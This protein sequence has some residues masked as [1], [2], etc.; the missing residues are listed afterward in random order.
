MSNNYRVTE[1]D[2][3]IRD[4]FTNEVYNITCITDKSHV[5]NTSMDSFTSNKDIVIKKLVEDL[6]E[7]NNKMHCFREIIKQF[8]N[9]L[10]QEIQDMI[11]ASFNETLGLETSQK[12]AE[13][14]EPM[15][16]QS[17]FQMP[18]SDSQR[19]NEELAKMTAP[20]AAEFGQPMAAQPN[21]SDDYQHKSR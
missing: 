6:I 17:T 19:I 1:S 5:A 15:A 2:G 14:S 7:T 10:P 11:L 20:K 16:A 21:Y 13:F 18:Q 3:S 8:I 4:C 12:A 9:L